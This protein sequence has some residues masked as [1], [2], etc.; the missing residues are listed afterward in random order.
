M[1]QTIRE[2][3]EPPTYEVD[4]HLWRVMTMAE[5]AEY[6]QRRYAGQVCEPVRVIN[7]Q[8]CVWVG[9]RPRREGR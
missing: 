1:I 9:F 6:Q 2:L 3:S 5:I 7:G 8:A 4:E